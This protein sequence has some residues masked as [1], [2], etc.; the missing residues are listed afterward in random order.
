M[1]GQKLMATVVLVSVFSLGAVTGIFFDRHHAISLDHSL[2]PGELHE[3]AMAEMVDVLRLDDQQLER[4]H[5]ILMDRQELV[6]RAWERMRPQVSEAMAEVHAEIAEVL[7][8]EQVVRY[9]EW[10]EK[11]RQQIDSEGG[12]MIIPH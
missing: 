12:V 7:T 11:Q 5:N 3:A 6:Q 4:I 10:L 1:M 9:H 2:S 8:P